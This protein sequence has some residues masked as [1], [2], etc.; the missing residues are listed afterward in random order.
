MARQIKKFVVVLIAA[1]AMLTLSACN[2][3]NT[4]AQP[5]SS[6]VETEGQSIAVI[7]DE[8][9]FSTGTIRSDNGEYTFQ[10]ESEGSGIRFTAVYPDGYVYSQLERDGAVGMPLDYDAS[11]RE[12]KGYIDGIA[13]AWAVDSAIDNARG[14]ESHGDAS[15]LL[16][17][18]LIGCGAW[19]LFAPKSVWWIAYGWRYKN[20][21]PS[22]IALTL[23]K[24]LGILL[25]IAGAICLIASF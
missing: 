19:Y 1:L 9:T 14:G 2:A 6:T 21:E 23:F 11:E 13:L 16:A 22:D 3:G 7:F 20:A 5:R 25:M 8:N 18:L 12:A 15:P 24:V 10:Y 17:V 4:S